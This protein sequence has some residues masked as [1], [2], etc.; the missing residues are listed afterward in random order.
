MLALSYFM[1]DD[2]PK[3]A[4]TFRPILPTLPDNPS[5]LYAAGIS[6]AKSG[7]SNGA[8]EIFRRMLVQNPDASE[9]HLYLGQAHAEE[10][11]DVEALYE[12]SLAL[13]LDANFA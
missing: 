10:E 13:Q 6:L 5:L 11:D 8:S 12:F 9:D 2:F 3:A 1:T 7:D 4:S